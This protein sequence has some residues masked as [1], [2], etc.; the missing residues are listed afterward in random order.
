MLTGYARSYHLNAEVIEADLR[1]DLPTWI[2]SEYGPGR[3]PPRGLFG[4]GVE[5]SPEEMRTLYYLGMANGNV[6]EAVSADSFYTSRGCLLRYCSNNM[7]TTSSIKPVKCT[8]RC[9]TIW[10][11]RSTMS[12]GAKQSTPIDLTLSS[13]P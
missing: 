9:S 13:S 8:K 2:L 1:D 5:M 10:T 6:Q 3:N 7:R 4:S 11:A 12:F